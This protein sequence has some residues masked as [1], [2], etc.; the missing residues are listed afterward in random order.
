MAKTQPK[1]AFTFPGENTKASQQDCKSLTEHTL[2]LSSQFQL[3][4]KEE[5]KA[6]LIELEA[7][8]MDDLPDF[9]MVTV[10]NNRNKEQ[11]E[12]DLGVF[13]SNNTSAF[14]NWLHAVWEKL[15]KVT[16]EEVSK[17]T[18]TKKKS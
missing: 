10:A 12:D 17:K 8:M 15:K 3:Y 7:Y 1:T 5:I 6:K 13:L 11:M 16:L 9:I 2:F 4:I 14:I 18:D